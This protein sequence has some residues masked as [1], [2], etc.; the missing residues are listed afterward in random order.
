MKLENKNL[1]GICVFA[2][3]L[4][5]AISLPIAVKN[6][7]DSSRNVTVKGLCEQEVMADRAIWPIVYKQAGDKINLI[8]SD[9][10]AK[11]KIII[12]WLRKAGFED[13]EIS[14]AAPTIEDFQANGYMEHRAFNYVMTSVIT[15]CTSKVQE[16]VDLQ[17][18][19]F[20]LLSYGIPIGSGNRWDFPVKYEYTKLNEIK[21]EMIE[22]AT[23]NA[24]EAADK[25]AKDSGASVGKIISANQGQF[26]I[27]DRDSNT[28]YMKTV[29]V[30]TTVTY[31][32]K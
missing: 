4:A 11:N 30:V 2:G 27:T 25:F 12:E 13:S 16:V 31:G 29:R 23:Q 10:E 7:T 6:Y 18:K 20:D 14:I 5:I 19:Q 3:L 17:T 1:L 8:A 22:N 9:V 15:V 32:I 24:R 21:P 28:P 26:S